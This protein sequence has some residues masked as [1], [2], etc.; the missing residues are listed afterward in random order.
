MRWD[1]ISEIIKQP[2]SVLV[3]FHSYKTKYFLYSGTKYYEITARQFERL[4]YT[5][6]LQPN[7]TISTKNG[8]EERLYKSKKSLYNYDTCK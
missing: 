1:Q 3:E 2:Y 8:I 5:G 4:C 7:Y 6:T